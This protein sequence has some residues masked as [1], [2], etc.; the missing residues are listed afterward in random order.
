MLDKLSSEFFQAFLN[1][2]FTIQFEEERQL[3]AKLLRVDDLKGETHLER[4]PF[5][6]TFETNQKNEYYKQAVYKITHPKI[7]E[8][9]YLFL[10]PS[11]QSQEGML[12]EVVFS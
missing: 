1:D 4:T 6:L 9:L 12:Y 7:E 10:V 3:E 8:E 5:A 2:Q 11:G